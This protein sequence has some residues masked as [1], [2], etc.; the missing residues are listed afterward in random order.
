MTMTL[1]CSRV[2]QVTCRIYTVHVIVES[3]YVQTYSQELSDRVI[4]RSASAHTMPQFNPVATP[5]RS[6]AQP[7]Y[8][9]TY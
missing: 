1:Y 7:V 9:T 6:Q 5:K 2:K 3:R 8:G 4:P